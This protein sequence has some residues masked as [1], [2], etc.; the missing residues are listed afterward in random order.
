MLKKIDWRYMISE[1]F[2]IVIGISIAIGLNNWNS[3]RKLL[4]EKNVALENIFNEIDENIAEISKSAEENQNTIDFLS[5]A[6]GLYNSEG[7]IVVLPS[8]IHQL[9]ND[10]P[11]RLII[12]DSSMINNECAYD[13]EIK[14]VI[15]SA[16]LNK[17]AWET[18]KVNNLVSQFE[19]LR[20]KQ[21]IAVY[22]LQEQY[23]YEQRKLNDLMFDGNLDQLLT[24]MKRL[25]KLK[26]VLLERYN[27]LKKNFK[28]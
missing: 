21:I 14:Y 26:E 12:N 23:M 20:V 4:N 17:I 1:I 27:N 10:Y 25:M 7:K 2:L 24:R 18:T 8:V 15:N 11:N 19:F 6:I 3:N 22:G 9:K 5:I 28:K 13:L 16:E